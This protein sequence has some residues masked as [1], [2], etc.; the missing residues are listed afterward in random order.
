MIF[1][2]W[3]LP[4]AQGGGGPKNCAVACAIHVSKSHTDCGWISEKLL[5]PTPPTVPPS[6]TPWAWPKQSNEKPVWYVL[7]LSFVRR[8]TKFGLKIFEIDLA[9]EV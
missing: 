5:L 7:Y 2:L 4:K 3:P 1:Y 9:I 8:H 6:P